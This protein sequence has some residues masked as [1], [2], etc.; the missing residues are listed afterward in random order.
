MP[1]GQPPSR[2]SIVAARFA[3][4]GL[5]ALTGLAVAA[6]GQGPANP[7]NPGPA[8]LPADVSSGPSTGG[9]AGDSSAR[10]TAPL[11]GLTAASAPDAIRPAVALVVAGPSPQ[12]LGSADVVFE[13]ITTPLRYIAIYQSRA[14]TGVGPITTTRPADGQVLSVLHPLFGYDGGTA[15]A[16]RNLDKTK[17]TDL[18]GLRYPSLYT[19]TPQG[20]TASTQTMA[21]AAQDGPPPPLFSY[22]GSGTNASDRFASTGT[23]HATSVQLTIPGAG[24]QTWNYDQHTGRWSQ[25]GGPAAQ[26]AN[27]VIQT[28]PYKAVSLDARLGLTAP[29]AEVIGTG[30][31]EVLSGDMA[32]DGTWAKRGL[33]EVTNYFDKNGSPLELEPGPTWVILAPQGTRVK[34]A[35]GQP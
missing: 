32:A 27:L 34:T 28:V 12:G 16:V 31:V 21:A 22:R 30:D 5:A 4:A 23:W 17:V 29:S 6:C 1:A 14:A 15:P 2:H 3:A 25:S 24:T 8:S 10:P 26:I 33:A 13:E 35:G 19:S 18:G 11:T 7:V 9:A 20:L